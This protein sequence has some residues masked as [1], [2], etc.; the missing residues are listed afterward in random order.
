M[1]EHKEEIIN[2]RKGCL[3][4]SDAKM[5]QSIAEL[6]VVPKSAFKRM[7][8]CKGLCEPD[9]FTNPAM[10]LGN[11]I[12]ACVYDDLRETDARWQSNPRL[13]SKKYSRH[14]VK[15]IDHVDFMLQDDDKKEL[16]LAECKATKLT[17]SQTRSEYQWQLCHHYLLGEEL[18]KEL[19]YRLKILLVHYNTNDVDYENH[20]YDPDR[21]TIKQVKNL[22]ALAHLYRLTEATMIVSDFLETFDSY[23]ENDEVD[24][25]YLPEKVKSEFN[26]MTS[27]LMEIK[28]REKVVD[29]FKKRLCE[30]MI[31]K[32]IKSII[33]DQ[34]TISLVNET[35]AVSFDHKA[36]IADLMGKHP[37]K[38]KKLLKTFEKRVKRNAYVT[39]KIKK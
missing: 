9:N 22:G 15:V 19:G 20:N 11:F 1:Y 5:L 4:G 25:E 35:E 29:D 8:V 37:R 34:W 38:A 26:T 33:N 2:T 21:L 32:N 14:N 13:V 31:D 17:F 3:G 18:A 7:A 10:E 23:Y 30:F 16:I 12:E 27:I 6:G 39:I 24:S 36:F 28:E